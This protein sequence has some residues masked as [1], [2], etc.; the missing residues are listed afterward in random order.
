MV[1]KF[2]SAREPLPLGR[3]FRRDQDDGRV[4]PQVHALHA[5][6]FGE[7]DLSS[8]LLRKIENVTL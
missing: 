1:P 8:K 6:Y 4:L 7:S 2:M 3:S 5:R